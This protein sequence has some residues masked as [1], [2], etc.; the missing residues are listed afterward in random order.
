MKIPLLVLDKPNNNGYIYPRAVFEKTIKDYVD[1]FVTQDQAFVTKSKPEWADIDPQD[2]VGIIKEINIE[3]SQVT[4]EVQFLKV[5]DGLA[6][7][8][9][10]R[11]G[12]LYLRTAGNVRLHKLEDDCKIVV[13]YELIC[14][15]LT[16]DPTKLV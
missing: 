15:Y 13:E 6:M 8:N 16:C 4:A 11:S 5:P 10:L 12:D 7:Q 3:E 14:C 2:V 9:A 1:K